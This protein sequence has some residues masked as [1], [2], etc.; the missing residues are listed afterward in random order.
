MVEKYDVAIIGGGL[1]G[2][3]TALKLAPAS[4]KGLRVVLIDE[5]LPEA[6][7]KLGGF[8]K[9]SGAKF[10]LPPAGMGLLPMVGGHF[11][12][13]SQAY[14]DTIELLALPH[15]GSIAI[16]QDLPL[17]K[18]RL[19]LRQYKSILLS[20]SELDNLLE[21]AE[22][23]IGASGISLVKAR[24]QHFS[25]DDY[26]GPNTLVLSDTTENLTATKI[27]FAAGRRGSG[28]L[29]SCSA[30]PQVGK[31]LDLGLRIEFNA[32]NAVSKLRALGP[33]A[34]LLSGHARTFC[35][36]SPGRVFRYDSGGLNIAG[37]VVAEEQHDAAN[38]GLLT[39]VESKGD[40]LLR[41]SSDLKVVPKCIDVV[42]GTPFGEADV[43]LTRL[44]GP[45]CHAS[46]ARLAEQ[47]GEGGVIDWNLPHRIHLPLLDWHWDVFALPN[48][49]E[50]SI[51][52]VFAIGD[53][54]GHARG[55]LQAAISGYL[56]A[57]LL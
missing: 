43:I 2:L 48:T 50:T 44:Y 1:A 39:R 13:L 28:I 23:L 9:F 32:R 27:V 41:L 7:G 37:G 17:E 25:S 22:R 19:V 26:H 56:V 52:N 55:L 21:R 12:L 30:S 14:L 8:A 47:L 54:S 15:S 33:D 11:D 29:S 31:G 20:P 3:T 10:S 34:K 4:K 24:L 35:L 40:I 16:S 42:D 46:L 49:F 38:F 57:G 36:N 6:G 5:P 45:S 51:T 18:T 53:C